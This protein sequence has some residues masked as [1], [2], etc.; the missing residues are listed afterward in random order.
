[1]SVITTILQ[2]GFCNRMAQYAFVRG[3][4]ERYG[5]TLQTNPWMGQKVFMIDDPPIASM[6]MHE[7]SEDTIED[8]AGETD[9]RISGGG[10]HQHSLY[11]TRAQARK[12]FTFRPE[13]L[14]MLKAV[15]HFEVAAHLRWADFVGLDDFVT[16]SSKS[17]FKACEKFGIDATKL[18]FISEEDPIV[19]PGFPVKG[20]EHSRGGDPALDKGLG[21][22]PDFYALMNADIL[23]RANSTFSLMAALIGNNKRVFCPNIVGIP[24]RGDRPLYQDVPFVEGNHM[25]ITNYWGHSELHW[26]ES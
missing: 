4:A 12:W 8:W 6:N 22:L 15:P 19:L 18:R 9:I 14:E 11:Y 7:R 21:F 13:I 26:K 2:E 10:L 25:P 17:Y 1:M 20:N 23:L 5:C 3:Y 16:I 24:S